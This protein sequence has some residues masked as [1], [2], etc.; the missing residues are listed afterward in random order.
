MN[1]IVHAGAEMEDQAT[2][3]ADMFY[4][5]GTHIISFYCKGANRKYFTFN[6]PLYNYV[7][8]KYFFTVTPAIIM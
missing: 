4:Q 8:G 7:I 6:I 5:H 1:Y 3:P 2:S